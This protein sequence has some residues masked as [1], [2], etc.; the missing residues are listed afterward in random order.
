MEFA[1]ANVSDLGYEPADFKAGK[2]LYADIVHPEDLEAFNF[3]VISNSERGI[4]DYT[5]EY[6]ILT[7]RGKVRWVEDMTHIQY[8]KNGRISRYFG[9]VSDITPRKELAEKLEQEERKFSSL[10]NSSSNIVI[11]LDRHGKLLEANERAYTCLGYS[12]EEFLKLTPANIDTRY[13]NQF[14]RQV[15]KISQERKITF[16]TNYLKKDRTFIPVEAEASIVDYEGKT[17]V[18]I[19]AR[20]ISEQKQIKREL[21]HSLRVSK[22]LELIISSS[23]VIVFLS[24]PKEKRP[25]EFITENIILF[26]YPAGA[27]TSGEIAYEDI[28]H[29]LDAEKVRDNL[30]RNYTEGRNDFF[31]E[32]RIL[33][34]SGEIRWVNEQ[35]FIH[36][37]E[38]GDIEYLYG[39]VVDVTEKRQSSDFLRLRRDT[40]AAL[41][42]TDELLEIL[43]QLLDLALEVEPLDSGCIYLVDDDSGEMK[44]KTCRG[45]SPAFVKAASGFGKAQGLA[46]LLRA[47][48]PVYRQYFEI[49]KMISL[50]TPPEEKLRAAAFLPIF[51]DGRFVAVMQLSSHKA[52]E[53]SETARKQLETIA[54]ELGNEIGRIKEK[55]ELRQISSDFQEL[56][57]S[58]KDFIFIV[59]HEGCILYSNPAFRKHLS[60]TEKELLGKNILSFHPHNRVLEAAKSFSEILEGKTF[61]YSLPFVTREGS[62]IFAETRF[63]RGSWRGQEV[64]IALARSKLA[65]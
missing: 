44:I 11:I 6:R 37:D 51:S 4:K 16:E 24:S 15:K 46:N 38:K 33:T 10:L 49:K 58:I 18:L 43:R 36:S 48:K 60:Y 64:M 54:I 56:F 45:L 35:T 12:R 29:P 14:S 21:S 23:P 50:E 34:A 32:Y 62:E 57:K 28:I 59:D 61:L 30:F 9:I 7:K 53:I 40:G 47:G 3:G 2:I 1:S 52:D 19:V 55:A 39:T 65:K 22:V 20:D 42:S 41:A 17:A 8:G 26:G 63:S 25:V 13:G 27:F 31:Q 5:Q